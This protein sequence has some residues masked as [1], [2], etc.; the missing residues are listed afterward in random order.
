[1]CTA[2]FSQND[3]HPISR[4]CKG[5]LSFVNHAFERQKIED[6]WPG[7]LITF[8]YVTQDGGLDQILERKVLAKLKNVHSL[9]QFLKELYPIL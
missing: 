3:A 1:M 7:K 2:T 8:N 4:K 9:C 6:H 5:A